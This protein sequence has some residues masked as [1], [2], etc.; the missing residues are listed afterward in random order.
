YSA[1]KHYLVD[2][3]NTPFPILGRTAWF[4]ISLSPSDYQTFVNDSVSRGYNAIEMHVL[5]H[6]DRG[7]QPPYNGNHDL[8]FIKQLNGA[9]WDGGLNR[10]GNTAPD[11]TTPNEAYWSFV[12]AFLAYCESQGVIVFMFPAYTGWLGGSQGWMQEM[13][14]NGPTKMQ[15]YGT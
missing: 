14:A 2:A 5:D 9:N 6:D 12:D 13:S 3:N 11:F 8:T 10:T 4:V 7:N 1:N 15:T